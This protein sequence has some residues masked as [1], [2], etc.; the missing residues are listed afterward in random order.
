MNIVIIFTS[1]LLTNLFAQTEPLDP[2]AMVSQKLVQMELVTKESEDADKKILNAHS[3]YFDCNSSTPQI[4][5]EEKVPFP[6]ATFQGPFFGVPRDHQ[7]SYRTCY[8]NTAKNLLVGTSRGQDVASFLDLALLTKDDEEITDSGIGAGESCSVLNRINRVGYCPQHLAQLETGDFKSTTAPY[9]LLL[10]EDF[11]QGK[12]QAT[13]NNPLLMDKMLKQAKVIIAELKKNPN[14]IIPL[15]VVRSQIPGPW[16]IKKLSNDKNDV[17]IDFHKHYREFYPSYVSGVI[18]GKTREEIFSIYK[19]KMRP[20]IE[21]YNLGDQLALWKKS[22]IEATDSDWSNPKLRKNM[23]E[24]IN[25]LKTVYVG[26]EASQKEFLDSCE[27]SFDS[28]PLLTGLQPLV[29]HMLSHKVQPEILLNEADNIRSAKEIVQML[30]APACLNPEN[31]KHPK[32]QISCFQGVSTMT[33]VRNLIKDP[34]EQTK[35]LRKRVLASLL[36][37]YALGHSASGHINTV[38]GLRFNSTTKECELKIR[39][40]Q[41]GTSIWLSEKEIYKNMNGMTEV[42]RK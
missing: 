11:L 31:R 9:V 7:A 40:S 26:K 28:L 8:A 29:Q 23:Q 32:D 14:I 12:I 18:E 1:F 41:D 34:E 25:F 6:K 33:L 3:E 22:F 24:S 17:L 19:E 36:Q 42:R 2:H 37:G 5:L 27:E 38:V 21:K 16:V 35:V 39:E 20:F 10:L 15:P 13:K 4:S 30:V